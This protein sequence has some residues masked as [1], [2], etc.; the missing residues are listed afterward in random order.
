MEQIKSLFESNFL[1]DN[2][3]FHSHD[4]KSII[5]D[6]SIVTFHGKNNILIIED[7]SCIKNCKIQFNNDNSIIYLSKSRHNYL[8]N[9][10]VNN[11]NTLFIGENC[12]FNGI[13]NIIASE[14]QNIIIGNECLFSFNIWIRTAD[15]HLIYDIGSKKRINFSKSILIGDHAW[16]G[17][18]AIVL[19]GSRIGSGSILAAN[20]VASGKAYS[21]NCSF[22][23]NPAKLLREGIFWSRECVHSWTP[24]ETKKYETKNTPEWIYE[25]SGNNIFNKLDNELKSTYDVASRLSLIKRNLVE[26]SGKNRFFIL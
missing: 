16:I 6:N 8:L 23:G 2:K 18:N 14:Y 24:A 3:I 17:Q 4:A 5:F 1:K 22:G 12:Y 25:N 10:S 20:S 15:P 19:K 26:H 11:S 13:L 7:G 9:V 21:S